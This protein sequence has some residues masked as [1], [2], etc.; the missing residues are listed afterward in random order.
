MATINS[1]AYNLAVRSLFNNLAN[2]GY[3]PIFVDKFD[4]SD[5]NE[6]HREC[7]TYVWEDSV[8]KSAKGST[9]Q[10]AMGLDIYE[11]PDRLPETV[12]QEFLLSPEMRGKFSLDVFFRPLYSSDVFCVEREQWPTLKQRIVNS[13][14]AVELFPEL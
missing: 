2:G 9:A 10:L 13:K 4:S 7:T 8:C 3:K 14:L 5:V 1:T 11:T 12:S 6:Q